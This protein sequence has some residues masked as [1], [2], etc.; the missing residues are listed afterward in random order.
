MKAITGGDS[1]GM[2][3]EFIYIHEHFRI[4]GHRVRWINSPPAGTRMVHQGEAVTVVGL[5]KAGML[6]CTRKIDSG[7]VL[8]F[9]WELKLI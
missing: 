2:L 5:G 8:A 9:P 6:D 4:Y 7:Q 1:K 3:G